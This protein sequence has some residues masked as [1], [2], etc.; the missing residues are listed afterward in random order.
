MDLAA[1]LTFDPIFITYGAL[2]AMA[3]VPIYFG[4]RISAEESDAE[5]SERLSQSDAYWFPVIGSCVL[6]GF[7]LLFT[8]F[9]KEYINLLLTA[10]F[11]V[12]GALS[13]AKVFVRMGLAVVPEKW[14]AFDHL[15]VLIERKRD[16]M[17]RIVF[18]IW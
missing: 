10:Y 16:G 6:F 7:Y 8:Y 9:G 4:G 11:A 3:V 13:L 17:L 14:H 5:G 1:L 2:I 12:F 15:H 18:F